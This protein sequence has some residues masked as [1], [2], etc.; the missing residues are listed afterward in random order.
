M[1]IMLRRS[2]LS[3]EDLL[4]EVGNRRAKNSYLSA[5]YHRLAAR[6]GAKRAA[7]AVGHS[8]LVIICHLLSHP[9]QTYADLSAD[10]F[11]QR[12]PKRAVRHHVKQL[13][14]MGYEVTLATTAA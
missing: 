14:A 4:V 9:E 11:V 10:Y 3:A 7:L 8:I 13:M 12:D 2:T 5:Q 1:K 6:R